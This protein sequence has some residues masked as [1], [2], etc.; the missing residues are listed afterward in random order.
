MFEKEFNFLDG[1]GAHGSG[2]FRQRGDLEYISDHSNTPKEHAQNLTFARVLKN[3]DLAFIM[4]AYE[5][6]KFLNIQEKLWISSNISETLV[7]P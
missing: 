1:N 7:V 5:K 4:V 6:L 3:Y 2:I